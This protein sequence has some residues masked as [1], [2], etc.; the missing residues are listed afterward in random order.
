MEIGIEIRI[1]TPPAFI[2]L[3]P[4]IVPIS[5]IIPR[6]NNESERNGDDGI[7][8]NKYMLPLSKYK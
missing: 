1:I 2:S 8:K 3:T 4:I 5:E 7:K 6:S